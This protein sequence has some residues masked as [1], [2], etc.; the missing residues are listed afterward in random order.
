MT[1]LV[2]GSGGREHALAWRLRAEG[3]RVLCAPGNAGTGFVAENLPADPEDQADLT[4]ACLGARADLVVVGPEGPLAA[5]IADRLRGEGFAVFG[6]GAEAA[7]L[8]SSKAFAAAAA[9]RW[10]VPRARTEVLRT[11]ADLRGY[12]DRTGG[13]RVLKKSGLA[14]GKGV[15]ESSDP[16]V[17]LSFGLGVLSDDA[18]LAEEFLT[19][20]EL[21]VFAVCDGSRRVVLPACADHKKPLPGNLGPN[22]GGMGALC[23]APRAAPELM[24]RVEAEIVEP[25]FRGLAAEG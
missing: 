3:H 4:R 18:L 20:P 6:P 15:L 5:G 17:L 11:E 24:A 14:A 2:V 21:S 13:K 8:E 1:V 12:L 22:T 25:T 9:Q 23:P 10:G 16:D 19:G 7:R